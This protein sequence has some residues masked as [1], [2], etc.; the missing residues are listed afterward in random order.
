MSRTTK[1]FRAD[2]SIK[3]LKDIGNL[4]GIGD[5]LE[6]QVVDVMDDFAYRG[7]EWAKACQEDW[8][9]VKSSVPWMTGNLSDSIQY[10]DGIEEKGQPYF[11]VGVD[12]NALLGPKIKPITNYIDYPEEVGEPVNVQSTDY[13]EF[14]ND[15][16]VTGPNHFIQNIW[17]TYADK[18][19]KEAMR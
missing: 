11:W 5:E 14:V 6:E 12:L 2:A 7:L 13:T 10:E 1:A 18:N 3:A 17:W 9:Q 16:N 8:S 19:L 15:R 4:F